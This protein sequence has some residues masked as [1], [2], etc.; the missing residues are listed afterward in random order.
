M[1]ASLELKVLT[2]GASLGHSCPLLWTMAMRTLP[3]SSALSVGRDPSQLNGNGG[4]LA[5]VERMVNVSS[6]GPY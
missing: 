6:F 1:S 4:T 5:G 3:L 2:T